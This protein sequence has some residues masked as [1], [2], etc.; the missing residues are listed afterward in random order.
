MILFGLFGAVID[1][2][3]LPYNLDLNGWVPG[4]SAGRIAD[5]IQSNLTQYNSYGSYFSVVGLLLELHTSVLC[6][7]TG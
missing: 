3:V 6:A 7:S 2:F 5:I 4:K 1:G